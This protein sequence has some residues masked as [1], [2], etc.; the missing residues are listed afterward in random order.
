MA[1]VRLSYT[2][3]ESAATVTAVRIYTDPAR[4]GTPFA[5]GVP[6][7]ASGV[8]TFSPD[9]PDGAYYTA[10]AV[11]DSTGSFT[12]GDDFFFV[13]FGE[14]VPNSQVVSLAEVRAHLNI[15]TKTNDS[16][17][18]AL[19]GAAVEVIGDYVGTPLVPTS[20]TETLPRGS[21]LILGSS[22][23]RSLTSV[24]QDGTAVTAYTLAPGGLLTTTNGYYGYGGTVTVTYVAGF[25]R[26][27]AAVRHAVLI[28][29]GRLW[30][31]QRGNAPSALPSS[32][33]A[34]SGFST[35]G[36]P[37]LP[38]LAVTLLQPYRRGV[39]VA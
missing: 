15:T 20:V 36:L 17:L 5:S 38:P 31:T 6:V 18:I 23:V 8:W 33:F 19:V 39:R 28:V 3:A 4:T 24:T 2:P 34:D 12:D 26:L 14:V 25:A 9:L 13:Q 11:T 7:L 35:G 1:V 37:L 27:P 29:V 16:E 22:N 32:D 30:E 10:W 21:T